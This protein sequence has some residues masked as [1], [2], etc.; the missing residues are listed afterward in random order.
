MSKANE[1]RLSEITL[2]HGAEEFTCPVRKFVTG[3]GYH[4]MTQLLQERQKV[5][6]EKVAA[7]DELQ[8]IQTLQG[9]DEEEL[10]E[11]I[12]DNLTSVLRAFNKAVE[13]AG[14]GTLDMYEASYSYNMKAI[15]LVLETKDLTAA[16]R[17][18]VESEPGSD[19]W[20]D[21]NYEEV[22]RVV[23]QFRRRMG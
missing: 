22:R 4:E 11:Y 5:S 7:I 13:I 14:G 17:K 16:Q 20:L 1:R 9:K 10:R 23:D 3:R 12:V 6:D 18:L 21:Q 15:R 19:F 8:K 2:Y